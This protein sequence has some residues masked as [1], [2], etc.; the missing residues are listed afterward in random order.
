VPSR[1]RGQRMIRPFPPIVATTGGT[2]TT[3]SSGETGCG[4]PAAE[5][6]P[7]TDQATITAAD[8]VPQ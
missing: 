4:Y 3:T 6:R 2:T 7:Q 5:A 8:I 1:P